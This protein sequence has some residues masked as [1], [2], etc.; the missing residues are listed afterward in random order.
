MLQLEPLQGFWVE[1]D[2]RTL[3]NCVKPLLMAVGSAYHELNV[4]YK[5]GQECLRVCAQV[6]VL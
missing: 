6:P 3:D 4:I 5:N 2:R 1:L